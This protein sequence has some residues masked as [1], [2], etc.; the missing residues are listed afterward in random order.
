MDQDVVSVLSLLKSPT[1]RDVSRK[2][3]VS[4]N[5]QGNCVSVNQNLRD[6]LRYLEKFSRYLKLLEIFFEIFRTFLEN[7]RKHIYAIFRDICN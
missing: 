1:P 3:K 7:F 4:V 2:R 5:L 6:I